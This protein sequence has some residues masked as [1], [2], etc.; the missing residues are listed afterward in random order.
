MDLSFLRGAPFKQACDPSRAEL[1]VLV[2]GLCAMQETSTAA[3]TLRRAGFAGTMCAQHPLVE[4][5]LGGPNWREAIGAQGGCFH[6]EQA[7]RA[8]SGA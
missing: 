4:L 7:L 3:R 5:L 1:G 2:A 8:Q 6:R